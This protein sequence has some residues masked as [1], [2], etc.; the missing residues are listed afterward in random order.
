MFAHECTDMEVGSEEEKEE[1]NQ[2]LGLLFAL[3]SLLLLL[4][5]RN[6]SPIHSL[7]HVISA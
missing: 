6:L 5:P 3:V 4:P 7:G 1:A 2:F